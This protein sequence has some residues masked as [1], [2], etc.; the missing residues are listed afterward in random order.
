MGNL[1]G[2]QAAECI[3]EEEP[4]LVENVSKVKEPSGGRVSPNCVT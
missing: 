3:R 4:V 1:E 2:L